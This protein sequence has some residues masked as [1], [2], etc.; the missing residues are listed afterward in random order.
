ML[1]VCYIDGLGPKILKLLTLFPDTV[2][3]LNWFSDTRKKKIVEGS[4][5]VSHGVMQS[6]SVSLPRSMM[7]LISYSDPQQPNLQSMEKYI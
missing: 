3:S 4:V 2:L 1:L 6:L 5:A 7:S